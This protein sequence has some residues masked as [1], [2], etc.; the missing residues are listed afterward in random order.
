MGHVLLHKDLVQNKMIR[1]FVQMAVVNK[2]RF[3]DREVILG[4]LKLNTRFFSDERAHTPV[5]AIDPLAFQTANSHWRK[6]QVR[7]LY[8]CHYCFPSCC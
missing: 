3:H 8:L 1:L 4:T 7:S 2:A 5:D 6:I